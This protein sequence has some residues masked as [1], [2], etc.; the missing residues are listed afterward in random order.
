MTWHDLTYRGPFDLSASTRFLE[1]FAPAARPDAA[2]VAG[3]LRL[4]FP[5]APSWRPVGVL[6]RQP[7]PD[8]PVRAR[9]FGDPADVAPTLEHVRRILSLD[10]DGTGFAEVAAGDPVVGALVARYPGLRPVSFHSPYEA[11]CWAIIGHR[12]RMAQAAAIKQRLAERLGEVVDVAGV[13]LASFPAPGALTERVPL[14]SE[15]KSDRLRAIARAAL[16]GVLDAATL[17]SSPDALATLRELPGIGPF[18]AELILLRGA[19]EPDGFPATEGRLHD[20]MALAYGLTDPKPAELA[21]IA[22]RWRPYR[23]WVSLLLRASR[24]EETA[25][26]A[27]GRRVKRAAG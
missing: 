7:E 23:T 18:S 19:G 20:E 24:E 21:T 10:V 5:A 13:A 12:I 17:R 4:A 27:T 14:V 25:E 1:G 15:L 16:D 3:E 6:V 2:A 26:I 22:Q 8:G 9:V 11:A